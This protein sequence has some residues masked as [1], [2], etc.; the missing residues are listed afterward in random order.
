MKEDE[1]GY[2]KKINADDVLFKEGDSG[3]EMYLIK[4]GKIRITKKVQD[5]ERLLAILDEGAFFGEM[6]VLDNSP[7]SA[8]ATAETDTELLTVDKE[9]FLNKVNENTFIQYVINT[10]IQRIRITN[11]KWLYHGIPNEKLR[12][13]Q[14]LISI[15]ERKED[16]SA[17]DIDT[18]LTVDSQNLSIATSLEPSTIKNFLKELEE[19]KLVRIK[20]TININS[21]KELKD[22]YETITMQEE[23]E[24]L[25]EYEEM[26]SLQEGLD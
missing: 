8:T 19:E 22:Y 3:D 4:K 21:L 23:F 15:A 14:Y 9:A 17:V 12:F 25:Q 1:L 24:R 11:E 20:D 10:L 18:G 5:K 13:L 2:T 7:R 16:K 6:S 26:K